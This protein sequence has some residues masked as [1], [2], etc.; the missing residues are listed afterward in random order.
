MYVRVYDQFQCIQSIL[1]NSVD[2]TSFCTGKYNK[3]NLLNDYPCY[4]PLKRKWCG[5]ITCCFAFWMLA[6]YMGLLVYLIKKQSF[7]FER[8]VDSL[9]V[10]SATTYRAEQEMMGSFPFVLNRNL[11]KDGDVVGFSI[12]PVA[13]CISGFTDNFMG[14]AYVELIPPCLLFIDVGVHYFSNNSKRI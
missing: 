4:I 10:H 7:H 12:F 9:M 13:H 5:G 14:A 1:L 3:K 8:L 6:E 11:M 2:M